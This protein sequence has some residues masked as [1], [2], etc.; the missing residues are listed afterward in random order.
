MMR[1]DYDIVENIMD[2]GE[3][4]GFH[5]IFP[6]FTMFSKGFFFRVRRFNLGSIGQRL[7]DNSYKL[8]CDASRELVWYIWTH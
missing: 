3:N 1:F 5:H 6:L 8:L 4:P 2:K 7:K